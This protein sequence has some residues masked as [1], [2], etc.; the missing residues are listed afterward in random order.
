MQAKEIEFVVAF[1]AAHSAHL[2]TPLA[3]WQI[4]ALAAILRAEAAPVTTMSVPIH[5]DGMEAMRAALAPGAVLLSPEAVE[6]LVRTLVDVRSAADVYSILEAAG[7]VVSTAE[8]E[9]STSDSEGPPGPDVQHIDAPEDTSA[10]TTVWVAAEDV[11]PEQM[12][13]ASAKSLLGDAYL[14]N[15]MML[16]PEQLQKYNLKA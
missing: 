1:A 4:K 13:F 15:S 14:I 6:K 3:E 10:P 8:P 12:K 11:T 16:T 5:V 9:A 2:K 7:G